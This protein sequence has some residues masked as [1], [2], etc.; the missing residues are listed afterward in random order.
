MRRKVSLLLAVLLLAAL[1]SACGGEQAENPGS[2]TPQTVSPTPEDSDAPDNTPEPS[3]EPTPSDAAPSE[4]VSAPQEVDPDAIYVSEGDM[5]KLE[6][7]SEPYFTLRDYG[8]FGTNF[9]YFDGKIIFTRE[10]FDPAD[11]A[12]FRIESYMVFEGSEELTEELIE[13]GKN[14]G[15]GVRSLHE[16]GITG[17]GVNVAIIDKNLLLDHPEYAGNVA[18]YYDSGC[19]QPEDWGS[20]HAPAVLSLLAGKSVGVAPGAKVWFAAVPSKEDAAYYAD[21][22]NWIIEQNRALPEGEKIRVVSISAAPEQWINVSQW[23]KAVKTAEAEGILVLDTHESRKAGPVI[24]P[25]F[26]DPD[27]PEDVT[28]CRP[29]FPA[30]A[31]SYADKRFAKTVFVPCGYRTTAQ[32]DSTGIYFYTYWGNAGLSWGMPYAAG[33]LALGWQVNPALDAQTMM[34]LLL[35]SAYVNEEG[36]HIIDPP[37]FIELV[38][39]TVE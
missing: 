3:D 36:C 25:A 28:R 18:A 6:R 19:E 1:F 35:Q 22:L 16:Q 31:G 15:L 12:T 7:W 24:G 5:P 14:P 29:G 27:D 38:R 32:E 17:E 39:A 9:R 20:S 2:T 10:M 34:D 30:S 37:V 8:L 13:A 11:L 4:T 21:C 33:V 23:N 26:Y